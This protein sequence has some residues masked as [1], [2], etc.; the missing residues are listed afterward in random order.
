MM[1]LI[2]RLT[3]SVTATLEGA[4]GQLENHDAIIDAS[5]K[6]TR[7]AVAKTQARLATLRQQQ[8]AYES[9]LQLSIEQ[10]K[11][12]ENRAKSLATE[13]ESKAL[14]C[15]TRR[16]QNE[17]ESNR[18]KQS[19]EQQDGLI[20]SVSTNLSTLKTKLDEMTQR[21]N[22]M[23]SRQ[24]VADVSKV[25]SK[26]NI[27]EQLDETFERW[28][29]VV[30]ETELAVSDACCSDPLEAQ[31]AQQEDKAKLLDQ[32]SALKDKNNSV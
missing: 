2:K 28:E 6:Q 5:I 22:L 13:N 11:V 14:Q 20:S 10:I 25:T 31:F 19:I 23:R 30:L 7:Q 26:S 15:L 17:A 18:L 27:S 29:S 4:V 21:H 3:T 1:N 12:W 32:L 24:A 9:Q 16:N 8:N